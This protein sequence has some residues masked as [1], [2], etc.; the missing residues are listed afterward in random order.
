VKAIW[1]SYDEGP[2][3]HRDEAGAGIGSIGIFFATLRVGFGD[4]EVDVRVDVVIANRPRLASPAATRQRPP[5]L[6]PPKPRA[7]ARRAAAKC[8]PDEN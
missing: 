8:R 7:L 5:R 6:P 4:G 2:R 1:P 3:I